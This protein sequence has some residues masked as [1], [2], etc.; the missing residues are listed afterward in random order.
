LPE[1]L[2]SHYQAWKVFVFCLYFSG[3]ILGRLP[4]ILDF[5]SNS[6]PRLIV[7]KEFPL[8]H[9]SITEGGL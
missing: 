8:L 5:E 2:T 1:R 3:D 9:L 7:T 6:A 4:D